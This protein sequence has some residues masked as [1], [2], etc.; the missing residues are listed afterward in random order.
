[1]PDARRPLVWISRSK[2]DFHRFPDEVQDDFMSKL[3][4]AQEGAQDI[5]GAKALS[6]GL[7][8]GLGIVELIHGFDGDTYRAVYTA[9]VGAVLAVLHVFKKKSKS[10]IATPQH[11]IELIRN[12]YRTA[13]RRYS[14]RRDRR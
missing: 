8:K 12:R 3:E 10:G 11:D 13:V 9:K 1:M 2:K 14:N 5:P 7:L 6:Q 4:L